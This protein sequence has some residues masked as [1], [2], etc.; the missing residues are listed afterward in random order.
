[1][2][3]LSIS[4]LYK[5]TTIF[6]F[7]EAFALEKL[8]GTSANVGYTNGQL[9]VFSGGEKYENF[10]KLFDLPCLEEALKAI[11]TEILVYG[12]AYGGKCQGMKATYGPDLKFCVFDVQIG[13]TWLNVPNAEDVAKK[14]G[15]EF[16]HYTLIST[17]LVSIDAER[18]ADSVQAIRNGMGPGKLREGIVLRPLEEMRKSNGER[19]IVKHKRDEFRETTTPRVVDPGKLAVEANA[20]AI[21]LEYVTEQR[22]SH[23]LDKCRAVGIA[24]TGK[25]IAAMWEDIQREAE[26]EIIVTHAARVKVGKAT[27]YLW[28]RRLMRVLEGDDASKMAIRP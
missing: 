13:N 16:V 6:L 2:G 22:L 21:A 23:V 4:N 24:D 18:D 17:D 20:N 14:L 7:K 28:K 27:A 10:A 3:Y 11:S 1:M 12:E 19:V 5:E 26:G 15:L 8:H 9:Q 25:V